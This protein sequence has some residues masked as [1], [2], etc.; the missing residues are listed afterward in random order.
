[1][2]IGLI[3]GVNYTL[4]VLLKDEYKLL[5]PNIGPNN[6]INLYKHMTLKRSLICHKMLLE[7]LYCLPAHTS[8]PSCTMITGVKCCL[9]LVSFNRCRHYDLF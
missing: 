8:D 5:V 6:S 7:S 2:I 1:M 3:L 4:F 9:S